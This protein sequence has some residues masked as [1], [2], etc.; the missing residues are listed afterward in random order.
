MIAQLHEPDSVDIIFK[1][2]ILYRKNAESNGTS[3]CKVGSSRYGIMCVEL[4][5]AGI[6]KAKVEYEWN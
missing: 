4:D 2:C 6:L 3:G 5:R 1:L